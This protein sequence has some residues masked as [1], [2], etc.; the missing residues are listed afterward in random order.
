M[1]AT[2]VPLKDMIRLSRMKFQA[3]QA[4]CE[5]ANKGHVLQNS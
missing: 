4:L 3:C 5:I 2:N 1:L